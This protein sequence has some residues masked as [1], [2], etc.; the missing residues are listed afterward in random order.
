MKKY[1]T[2]QMATNNDNQ[3]FM[4][5]LSEALNENEKKNYYSE[6]HYSVNNNLF[7]ALILGYTGR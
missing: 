3:K 4:E 6:I 7:T 5:L 1:T 2:I